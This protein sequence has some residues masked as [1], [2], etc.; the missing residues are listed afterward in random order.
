VKQLNERA[1]ASIDAAQVNKANELTIARDGQP[2]VVKESDLWTEV[3]HFGPACDAGQILSE[4]YP[5]PFKLSAD[6][7]KK[8]AELNAFA[9]KKWGIDPLCM[10]LPT[11]CA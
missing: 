9:I 3:F 1:G 6:A 11:S 10:T 5:E 4:K 7:E 8:K 2:V